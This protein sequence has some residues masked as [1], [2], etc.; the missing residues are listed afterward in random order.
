MPPA[1]DNVE[2]SALVAVINVFTVA[3]VV[4]YTP[5]TNVPE[6][7]ELTF[8]VIAVAVVQ[9]A[10]WLTL[11]VQ[12]SPDPDTIYVPAATVPPLSVCPTATVPPL[13]DVNVKVVPEID[14]LLSVIALPVEILAVQ[15]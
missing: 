13:A 4:I 14:A 12:L 10:V 7:V 5:A 8:I 11:T 3:P 9:V 2:F 15:L 6:V 1:P